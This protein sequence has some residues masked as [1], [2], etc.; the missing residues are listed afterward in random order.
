MAPKKP[1]SL[2]AYLRRQSSKLD[3]VADWTESDL[4][5]LKPA[6]DDLSRAVGGK[7]VISGGTNQSLGNRF[8]KLL[9]E[10][11]QSRAVP[12]LEIL[13]NKAPGYPDALVRSQKLDAILCIE[14]KATSNWS[15]KDSLRRVLMSA[16]GRLA[17]ARADFPT[18]RFLHLI[19]SVEYEKGQLEVTQLRFHF[20][21]SNSPVSYRE[22]ISTSQK[23]LSGVKFKSYTPEVP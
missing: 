3:L 2:V 13:T 8:E 9:L 5:A 18:D 19:C 10:A 20:L 15:G 23:S 17:S 22:E 6:L 12:D 1:S 4:E 7:A 14:I 21:D 11:L 16:V